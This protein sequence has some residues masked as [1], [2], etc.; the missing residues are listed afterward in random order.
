M[1]INPKLEF[2]KFK[3]EHKIET[4]KTFRDFAIEELKG[5]NNISNRQ[6]FVLC[7]E[8]FIKAL[9]TDHAIDPKRKKSITIIGDKKFNLYHS[10]QPSPNIEENYFQGVINGG[11]F[12][13]DRII[14]NLSNK[15]DN[16]PLGKGK[17]VLYYYYIFVYFPSNHHEGFFM[18]HSN[19]ADDTITAV[20]RSYMS[21]LF[22][23]NNYNKCVI[24][25][26][27]PKSFQKE[28][29]EGAIVKSI[30][31]GTTTKLNDTHSENGREDMS[32]LFNVKIEL[33]PIDEKYSLK[34][35]NLLMEKLSNNI[36]VS[37]AKNLV[38]N[39]FNTKKLKA[40]NQKTKKPKIFEWNTRD[41]E[42][43]PVVYLKDRIK[44]IDD[45]IPDFDD[46]KD[47][48]TNLF[49]Q[50]ILEELRPDLNATKIG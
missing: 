17:S 7:F 31:Y 45:D 27:C 14:S 19:G 42:F 39:G 36:F 47:Y 3:L 33:I 13:K 9:E 5:E 37:G 6:A 50:E 44:F 26:F 25:A 20:F 15:N 4:N 43:V 18:I 46:L 8:H 38:L 23:G 21:N 40:E 10:K 16:S 28:Y 11:P 1:A 29:R 41:N 30:S 22:K 35:A 32:N 49:K 2:Y 12:G 48:C 24:Q 34:D